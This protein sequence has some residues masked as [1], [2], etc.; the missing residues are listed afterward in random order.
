MEITP[1]M[2]AKRPPIYFEEYWQGSGRFYICLAGLLGGVGMEPVEFSARA[3]IADYSRIFLR[4]PHCA[5]YQ[6]GLPGIGENIHDIARF[7]DRKIVESGATDV[8]FVGNCMGG[9]AAIL[10]CAL[11]GKG[12]AYAFSPQTG[13]RAGDPRHHRAAGL[14]SSHNPDHIYDLPPW[15]REH[16]PEVRADVY[17]CLDHEGDVAHAKAVEGFR[18]IQVHYLDKGGHRAIIRAHQLGI[19]QRVLLE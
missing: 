2:A 15:L 6:L 3:G 5:W 16:A 9:H 4:D 11:I 7:L 1:E 18:N 19:F 10:L 13:V 8:R 17:A 14:V 12:R